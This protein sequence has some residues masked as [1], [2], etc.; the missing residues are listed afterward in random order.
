VIDLFSCRLLGYAMSVHH[1]ADLV[2]ASLRMA[3]ATRGG[4]VDG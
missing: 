3:A 2:I 4:H 1:D